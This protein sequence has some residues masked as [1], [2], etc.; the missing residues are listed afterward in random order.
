MTQIQAYEIITKALDKHTND[1]YKK[2]AML[3]ALANYLKSR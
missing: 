3:K 2:I 1:D